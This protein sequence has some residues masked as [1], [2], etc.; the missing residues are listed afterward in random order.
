MKP[1]SGA[2]I[3]ESGSLGYGGLISE[4]RRYD[5]E[6]S[7]KIG[8]ASGDFKQLRRVWNHANVPAKR[9]LRYLDALVISRLLYGM[10]SIWLVTSQRRRL[11]G[12]YARC[13]R[14][15]LGIPAAFISR[16]SNATVFA[17]A[18]V[19]PLS[20][21]LLRRQLSL[22]GKVALSPQ[23]HPLRRDAFV[24]NTLQPQ[25][26]RFIRRQCRPRQ[27]W[28]AEVMKE[29]WK[30]LGGRRVTELLTNGSPLALRQWNRELQKIQ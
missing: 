6:L 7:R 11:D 22:L 29:A 9:R 28:I 2:L 17:R 14:K 1:S 3:P 23:G 27:D 25:I 20:N 4:N 15:V 12:F 16:I 30:Q 13:L 5:S 18:G 10:A 26:G 24:D 19:I 21:Q 8:A